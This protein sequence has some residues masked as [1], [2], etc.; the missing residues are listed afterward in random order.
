MSVDLR[1]RIVDLGQNAAFA[2]R[3]AVLGLMSIPGLA[4]AETPTPTPTPTP[5]LPERLT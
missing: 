2:A 1:Q 3:L 4:L 5:L